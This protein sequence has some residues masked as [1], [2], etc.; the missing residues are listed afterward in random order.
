M[1]NSTSKDT[2]VRLDCFS[3]PVML[4]TC[5]IETGLALCVL[6]SHW[7]K[8]YAQ[9]IILLLVC[10]GAFQ[11]AEYHICGGGPQQ[12]AWERLGFVA[13]ILLPPLGIH[14][15]TLVSENLILR[16]AA[17]FAGIVM[18]LV[19]AMVPTAVQEGVCG[20]NYV[21]LH[22][23]SGP[24]RAFAIYYVAMLIVG[25]LEI[26]RCW[27]EQP[28]TNQRSARQVLS[29]L[30][31]GYASFMVPTTIAYAVDPTLRDGIPSIMCGFAVSL[32]VVMVVK[33]VP[34]FEKFYA[35]N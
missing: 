24:G 30:A 28:K 25:I 6:I 31:L 4:A 9:I 15:V 23:N 34:D 33:I 5:A 1:S 13:I 14:L 35:H 21:I 8:G 20:G 16:R 17:H 22:S 3:P 32:A 29:S 12:V 11:G 10:L 19:F 26:V 18:A 7:R 2:S 27:V